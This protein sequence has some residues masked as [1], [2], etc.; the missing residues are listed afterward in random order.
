MGSLSPGCRRCCEKGSGSRRPCH[1]GARAEEGQREEGQP[2]CPGPPLPSPSPAWRA[3]LLHVSEAACVPGVRHHP[4]SRVALGRRPQDPRLWQLRCPSPR[5]AD[6]KREKV[7][8]HAVAGKVALFQGPEA[9]QGESRPS[10]PDTTGAKRR[11]T[12]SPA[13]PC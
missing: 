13:L 7:S 2:P 3:F 1:C 11:V 9:R 8:V 12:G 10:S 4:S 6:E 5:N